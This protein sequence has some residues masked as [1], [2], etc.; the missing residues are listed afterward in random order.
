M[1]EL[2]KRY[3]A[4]KRRLFDIYYEAELNPQQREAVCTAN[5]PLLILAGAGSGKT[6]VLVRRIVFLI[7]YGNAYES[8]AVPPELSEESVADMERAAGLSHEEI[9]YILPEFISEP[10]P[11]WSILAI[12]FTNKA[13]REIRERLSAAFDNESMAEDIWAGTF[14]SICVR[15]LRRFGERVGYASNFSIYDTDEKKRLVTECMK[16]LE[17]DERLLSVRTVM[18]EISRE[19]DALRAPGAIPPADLREKHI[20][21]IYA[22][23]NQRLAAANAVDFDDII[24]KTV[25]LLENNPDVLQY[26]QNRF[27]YVSVD[28][29]QDTNYAQFRLVELLTATRRNIMV[30]GDDDQSIYK[31]RGAT[32]ENI[33]NFDK[34]YPDAKVI[35]LEQNYRSTKTILDA[36]NAVIAHNTERHQKT[37][38]CAA[39]LGEKI[40]LHHSASQEK[41]AAYI[42]DKITE[43]VVRERRSYRDFAVLYRVNELARTLESSFTK[44]GIPYRVLGG[45]RFFDRKEIRD[46]VAYLVVVENGR[47]DQKLKRVINEPKRKIG[48]ATVDAIAEIADRQGISMLAVLERCEEYVAL[49]KAAAHLREFVSLI[50][51][52]REAAHGSVS[53]LVEKTI[54]ETGYRRMLEEAGE[55]GE[56]RLQSVNELVSAAMEYEK[57]VGEGASLSGFLEEV[58][59]V[60]DVDKYDEN[61]DAVVL[62]TIHSAKGLEFPVV[63]LAGMEEGIF[64]GTPC[65]ANP[66]EMGEER[67]LAYV[68][69]TRAKERLFLSCARSRLLYGRTQANP[70]SRFAAQEIPAGLLFEE[71]DEMP[72]FGAARGAGA[73]PAPGISQPHAPQRP[74]R[75]S[76]SPEFL[77]RASVAGGEGGKRKPLEKFGVGD[78]VRHAVYGPGTVLSARDMGGD[79]LYEVEFDNGQTKKLMATYARMIRE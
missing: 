36:A 56:T 9:G 50:H 24:M 67:R 8:N 19:K 75:M 4:A 22:A 23:Y 72:Y 52:L 77:Q 14:H 2:E 6:T 16:R 71:E 74:Q 70:V 45:Q 13:A 44:S 12:T 26:Y 31:F 55:E 42:V 54:S 58:A 65:F 34:T 18:N 33:L 35:K 51:R 47:D 30:V 53:A 17:I 27:R 32:I 38:W 68:A 63:F 20:A 46:I 76:I 7:K 59:L 10:C 11:P 40:V 28:E 62:M 78:R 66:E 79:V 61:A 39:G 41:E 15:I 73:R 25:E 21:R 43:L 69:I 49:S 48:Q 64:P 57:R 1:S 29:Y 5:G 3:L 60:S 37:L